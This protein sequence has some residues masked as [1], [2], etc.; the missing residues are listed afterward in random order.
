MLSCGDEIR[1]DLVVDP[2]WEYARLSCVLRIFTRVKR[3][4]GM[5]CDNIREHV[6]SLT[7]LRVRSHKHDKY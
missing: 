1:I 2:K 3:T 6:I 4:T 5:A 7:T